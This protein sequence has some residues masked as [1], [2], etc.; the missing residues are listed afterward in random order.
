LIGFLKNYANLRYFI[1]ADVAVSWLL[2]F[3]TLP[4]EILVADIFGVLWLIERY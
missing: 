2:L 1:K 3:A 4:V